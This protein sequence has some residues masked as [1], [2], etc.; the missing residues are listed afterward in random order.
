M[1]VQTHL[2]VGATLDQ[3]MQGAQSA[4]TNVAS[5]VGS[6]AQGLAQQAQG[7]LHNPSVQ[8]TIGTLMWWPFG[9]PQV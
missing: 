8:E 3:A 9:P 2:Q 1:K 6:A 7:V 5:A 4:L